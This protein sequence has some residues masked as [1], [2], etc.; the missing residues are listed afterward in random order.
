[1]ERYK[2]KQDKLV[3]AQLLNRELQQKLDA[4]TRSNDE[5]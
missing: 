4:A 5:L 1:M 2:D 3:K